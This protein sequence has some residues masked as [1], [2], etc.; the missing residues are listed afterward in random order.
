MLTSNVQLG[1]LL[2][3]GAG[4]AVQAGLSCPPPRISVRM[5]KQQI[6]LHH[7]IQKYLIETDNILEN[8]GAN[9]IAC[10]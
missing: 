1:Y 7:I 10:I 5:D 2:A 6:L 8:R 9:L 3:R 4:Q